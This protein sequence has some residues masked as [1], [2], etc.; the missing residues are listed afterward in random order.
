MRTAWDKPATAVKTV[1]VDDACNGKTIEFPTADAARE[2]FA[3]NDPKGV[4]FEHPAPD[5]DPNEVSWS[6]LP[7]QNLRVDKWSVCRG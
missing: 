2:W 1:W 7:E 4:A 3:V 5:A 6:R